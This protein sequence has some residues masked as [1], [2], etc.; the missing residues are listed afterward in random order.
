EP[1]FGSP[2]GD[3]VLVGGGEITELRQDGITGHGVGEEKNNER[4]QQRHDRRHRQAG[5]DVACHGYMLLAVP[6]R[7]QRAWG[8]TCTSLGRARR[9]VAA[10]LTP[11]SR[12]AGP[13][14]NRPP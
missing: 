6:R 3:E 11:G 12:Y 5:N 9:F 7:A 8:G 1:P 2:L 14:S 10:G 13:A 4:C